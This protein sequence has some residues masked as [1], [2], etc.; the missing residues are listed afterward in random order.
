MFVFSAA[1]SLEEGTWLDTEMIKKRFGKMAGTTETGGIRCLGNIQLPFFKKHPAM[2]Q[3][4]LTEKVKCR[5]AIYFPKT[6]IELSVGESHL[7]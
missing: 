3:P 1:L 6:L 4:L 2:L 7:A 5:G